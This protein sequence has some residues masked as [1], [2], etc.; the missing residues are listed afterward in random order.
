M[1]RPKTYVN[2]ML[3]ALSEIYE[4]P[5]YTPAEKLQ[6][7]RLSIETIDRRV[8]PKRKTDKD[9]ALLKALGV[10]PNATPKKKAPA[11]AEAEE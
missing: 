7:V 9:K 6:A 10:P 5:S 1:T 11:E 8:T 2:R 3:K 4:D